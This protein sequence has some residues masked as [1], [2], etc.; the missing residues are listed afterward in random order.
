MHLCGSSSR[1]LPRGRRR[2]AWLCEG[3]G[4]KGREF[5]IERV[6]VA[7]HTLRRRTREPHVRQINEMH[8]SSV[9]TLSCVESRRH[10]S[11]LELLLAS[12]LDQSCCTA[13]GIPLKPKP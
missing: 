1:K 12:T 13:L 5:E 9:Y 10:E 2:G 7:S 4:L 8:M 6:V 3:R 11:I